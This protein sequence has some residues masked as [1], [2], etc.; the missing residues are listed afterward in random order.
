MTNTE[1]DV[2]LLKNNHLKDKSI[3]SNTEKSNQVLQHYLFKEQILYSSYMI[4]DLLNLNRIRIF[5]ETT[6]DKTLY[7]LLASSLE[8]P[9]SLFISRLPNQ[10]PT[11]NFEEFLKTDISIKNWEL[12]DKDLVVL[13]SNR[14]LLR[15]RI[16][17]TNNSLDVSEKYSVKFTDLESSDP[18]IFFSRKSNLYLIW[19]SSPSGTSFYHVENNS[20]SLFQLP[21]LIHSVI[22]IDKTSTY[23][24]L[25]EKTD[26]SF[27]ILTKD[28]ISEDYR[29]DSI[30]VVTVSK[31][32][33][34]ERFHLKSN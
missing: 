10:E 27:L 33:Y 13:L 28:R 2:F 30:G 12:H 9:N 17:L 21:Y 20:D 23:L 32:I 8:D 14:E 25:E 5:T 22:P 7:Y 29:W 1:N 15:Y 11:L 18:Q 16:N 6:S 26:N 31:D 4:P 19:D 34:L 3:K 24:N